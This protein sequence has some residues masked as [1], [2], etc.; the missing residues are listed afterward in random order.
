MKALLYTWNTLVILAVI[1]AWRY[2]FVEA[3]QANDQTG[4]TWIIAG[5]FALSQVV[6]WW[7]AP[8]PTVVGGTYEAWIGEDWFCSGNPNR[9]TILYDAATIMVMLGLL[10]TV[11]GFMA[12]LADIKAGDT[13]GI[14]T[15]LWTTMVGLIGSMVN[16]VTHRLMGGDKG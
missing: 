14:S 10:G 15:A 11:I 16:F 12:A 7:P 13:S 9:A 3:T 5:V 6:A 1:A 2:G 8:K 4:I